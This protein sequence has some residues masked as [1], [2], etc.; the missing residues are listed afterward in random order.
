MMQ[1]NLVSKSVTWTL[2]EWIDTELSKNNVYTSLE[3]RMD[4]AIRLSLANVIQNTGGPFGA[5]IFERKSG[6]LVSAGVNRVVPT[7]C[8]LA[9]AE[10]VAI[11]FAQ[12]RCNTFDL[13]DENL[14]EMELVTS[15]QPC[16][17]CFG[18]LHWCGVKHVVIGATSEDVERHTG[19]EEGPLP[20]DWRKLLQN[21]PRFAIEVTEGVARERACEVLMLYKEQG[22]VIYIPQASELLSGY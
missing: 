8:S 3:E 20:N 2:P 15:A 10:A 18:M 19:F 12:Q 7:C 1:T 13:A 14:P 9:H 11:A 22:G 16:T 17:Q 21:R 6:T 4:L 5:C